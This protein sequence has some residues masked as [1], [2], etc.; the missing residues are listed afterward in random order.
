MK[1]QI[2]TQLVTSLFLAFI[3]FH[4]GQ[5]ILIAVG[6]GMVCGMFVRNDK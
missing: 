4:F 1:K 6:F 5:N 2:I 3:G